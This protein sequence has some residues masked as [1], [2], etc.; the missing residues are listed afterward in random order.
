LKSRFADLEAEREDAAEGFAGIVL[1]DGWGSR[2]GSR[3]IIVH[4][5]AGA[6]TLHF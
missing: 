6:A 4:V 5:A 3:M 2:S 1:G